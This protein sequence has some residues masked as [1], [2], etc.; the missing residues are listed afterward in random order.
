MIAL[1]ALAPSWFT[2]ASEEETGIENPTR[3]KIRGLT[4]IEVIDITPLIKIDTN[5]DGDTQVI[6]GSAAA[7]ILLA[8]GLIGWEGFCDSDGADVPFS[9]KNKSRIPMIDCLTIAREIFFRTQI[10]ADDKKK[11]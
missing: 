8:N 11:S 9:Q 5:E 4:G 6:L 1:D 2:P 3:F 7:N 10:T